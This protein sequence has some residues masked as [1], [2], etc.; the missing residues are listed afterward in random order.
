VKDGVANRTNFGTTIQSESLSTTN[1][2]FEPRGSTSVF[3]RGFAPVD[4]K[5]QFSEA[6]DEKWYLG[7]RERGREGEREKG[8]SILNSTLHT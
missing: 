8:G 4:V 7:K 1:S 5:R 2:R 3:N 6:Y